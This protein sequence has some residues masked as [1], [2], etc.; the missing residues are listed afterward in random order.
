MGGEE[1]AV[2]EHGMLVEGAQSADTAEV[3]AHDVLEVPSSADM[4]ATS[5]DAMTIVAGRCS[6]QDEALMKRMGG[7]SRPD[8]FPAE[9]ADCGRHAFRWFKFHS[10]EM[11]ACVSRKSGISAP[12]ASCFGEAGQFSF[13]NCKAKCMFKWCKKRCLDCTGRFNAATESCVGLSIAVPQPE[14]C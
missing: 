8:S 3:E 4:A 7:G 10:D 11:A 1:S 5:L 6:A 12:C 2:E 9:V 14:T 13:A